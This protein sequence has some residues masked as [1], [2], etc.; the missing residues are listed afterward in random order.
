M[1]IILE[2]GKRII[3]DRYFLLVHRDLKH[4]VQIFDDF[5][6]GPISQ[7]RNIEFGELSNFFRVEVCTTI[8]GYIESY[9]HRMTMINT[10]R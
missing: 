2:R 8:G 10:Y 1:N 7:W 4:D 3:K 9:I 5:F 6:P